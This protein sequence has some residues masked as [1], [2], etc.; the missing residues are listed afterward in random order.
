MRRD[1]LTK[2]AILPPPRGRLSVDSTLPGAMGPPK[3]VRVR[4]L[5]TLTLTRSG[6]AY[7]LLA[8]FSRHSSTHLSRS[9]HSNTSESVN[10]GAYPPSMRSVSVFSPPV[11]KHIGIPY[12]VSGGGDL[13]QNITEALIPLGELRRSKSGRT[14][15]FYGAFCNGSPNPSAPSH[16]RQGVIPC[17]A[18]RS[19]SS[20][21]ALF[22]GCCPCLKAAKV[23]PPERVSGIPDRQYL[24]ALSALME[25][26]L[27]MVPIPNTN[28][29]SD[30]AWHH[31]FWWQTMAT[32]GE[33]WPNLSLANFSRFLEYMD[34]VTGCP[35]VTEELLTAFER[36]DDYASLWGRY[37]AYHMEDSRSLEAKE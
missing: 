7:L 20:S 30:T 34:P 33:S 26:E 10:S 18:S 24:R 15:R 17:G 9:T 28:A 4:K 21:A 8:I 13:T 25:G 23:V 19:A 3:S 31:T 22:C 36:G 5:D 2:H 11:Q 6:G 14:P 12:Y 16:P 32:W 27:S 35:L 29:S 1:G 37:Q